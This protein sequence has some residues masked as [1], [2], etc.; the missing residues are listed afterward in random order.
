MHAGGRLFGTSQDPGQKLAA[1]RVEH[2]NK[3]TPIVND[4]LWAGIQR[5]RQKLVVFLRRAA[6]RSVDQDSVLYQSGS[7]IIL[8][9][10]GITAGDRHLRPGVFQ[11]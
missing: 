3:I 10:K 7:N 8:R 6:V 11:H 4:D 5:L 1:L 9:G 2:G